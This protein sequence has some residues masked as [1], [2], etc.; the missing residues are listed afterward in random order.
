V[1]RKADYWSICF[2]NVDQISKRASGSHLAQKKARPRKIRT[3]FL[4]AAATNSFEP[5]AAALIDATIVET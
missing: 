3:G 2:L 1:A 4:S 5:V